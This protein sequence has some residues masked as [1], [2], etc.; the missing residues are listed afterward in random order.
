M[1]LR[2]TGVEKPHS[3]GT[4]VVLWGARLRSLESDSDPTN[5][6]FVGSA[7]RFEHIL[8]VRRETFPKGQSDLEK[9][10]FR[11]DFAGTIERSGK[12]YHRFQ[13]Q[14]N[15]GGKI[16]MSWKDW[17]QRYAIGTDAIVTTLEDEVKEAFQSVEADIE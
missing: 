3:S 5:Q 6:T 1:A 12:N 8:P 4:A 13:V 11:S 15:A 16:P 2:L 14:V 7:V 17:R 9:M 10:G